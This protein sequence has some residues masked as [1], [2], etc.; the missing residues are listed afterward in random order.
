VVIP[1]DTDTAFW[2]K[3]FIISIDCFE[4]PYRGVTVTSTFSK[5]IENIVNIRGDLKIIDT[6]N[7]LQK[8]FTEN[9]CHYYVTFSL[10][11]LEE[12]IK[13]LICQLILIV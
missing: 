11:N 6:Q 9:L 12:K 2:Y 13:I 5:I 7:P 1:F 4:I 10:R 8:G 3:L